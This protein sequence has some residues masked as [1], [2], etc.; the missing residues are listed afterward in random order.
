MSELFRYKGYLLEALGNA[1]RS[2]HTREA[3]SGEEYHVESPTA[4]SAFIATTMWS[5]FH[6]VSPHLAAAQEGFSVSDSTLLR[7]LTS[8]L[9]NFSKAVS[10]SEADAHGFK[11]W[12]IV[13]TAGGVAS[14]GPSGTLQCDLY[15]PV[16]LPG[17]LVGDGKLGGISSTITAYESLLI[18]GYDIDAIILSDCGLANEERLLAYLQH[19]V[20]VMVLPSIPQDANDGLIPWYIQS[21]RVFSQ[22]QQVLERASFKKIRRLRGMQKKAALHL[23]WPFTQHSLVAE[24]EITVIDSRSGDNFMIYKHAGESEVISQQIDAC[25]SWWTQGPD[26]EFQLELARQIGYAAGR[27]GHVMLPENV[28]EPAL[29]CAELLIQTVGKGWADRVYYSDNGSTAIEIAIK[30]AF[31][32]YICDNNLLGM[33][34]SKFTTIDQKYNLKVLGLKGSYH[35]DTLGAQDAQAPSVYTGFL[36]QPWYQGRGLFLETPYIYLHNRQWHINVPD[37]YIKHNI[38]SLKNEELHYTSRDELYCEQRDNSEL[39]TVYK[40]I[41][42]EKLSSCTNGCTLVA[43]L[44]IE[45][46]IHGSGGMA[47]VDPLFQR[48]LVKECKIKKIP[49]I[50]DEVFS[51]CWR[52]GVQSCTELLGCTPDIGCYSK[53]LTGGAVPLSATLASSSI[54]ESFQ[55]NSK[56]VALLHGHSY[57]GHAIGCQ[58]AIASL[59]WFRDPARNPNLLAC[60]KRLRELWEPEIVSDMSAHPAAQRVIALGTVF[61]ME[62]KTETSEAGYSSMSSASIVQALRRNGV[63]VRPLGNVIYLMCG[64]TTP[65]STCSKVMWALS[66]QLDAFEAKH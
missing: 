62:L 5:W 4:A 16:R 8:L 53:L 50:F 22:L 19:R 38:V 41:I 25:A 55:G 59:Q 48:L 27:F 9:S 12:A 29:C 37:C 52:L 3:V 49:V 57:S 34:T 44:I 54:F 51:G 61:A 66:Q 63:Y 26:K 21:G 32:K 65:P 64:P 2:W 39:G 14:P 56:L 7:E 28:Y 42:S 6:A 33:S 60:K 1:D 47:L 31:R 17:L 23:W 30:M 24:H 13:E 45:P 20:P 10:S 18:R 15:R 43:A 36:Q 40:N 35:G 58:A 46:V 11:K